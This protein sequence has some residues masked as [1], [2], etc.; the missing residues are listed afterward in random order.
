MQTRK[1][2][3]AF[4]LNFTIK[5][6]LEFLDTSPTLISAELAE[7]LKDDKLT[8]ELIEEIRKERKRGINQVSKSSAGKKID[9]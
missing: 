3:I 4:P 9:F 2:D 6:F 8:E 5:K 1:I 7:K